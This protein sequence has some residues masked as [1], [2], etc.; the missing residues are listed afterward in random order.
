MRL[1]ILRAEFTHTTVNGQALG[2]I[3]FA[4]AIKCGFPSRR[5]MDFNTIARADDDE[6]A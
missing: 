2:P 3:N 5:P 6:P 4:L 1:R